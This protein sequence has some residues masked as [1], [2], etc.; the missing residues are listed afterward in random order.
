MSESLDFSEAALEVGT[1]YMSP[2]VHVVKITEV[3]AGLSSQKNTPYVEFTVS[4]KTGQTASQQYYLTTTIK[5]GSTKS[6]FDISKNAIL[7]LIMSS[8]NVD[9]VTAK[10]KLVGITTENIATKLATL[11]VGKTLAIRLNGQ[12]VN[13]TDTNK[14]SWVKAIFGTGKFTATV[15]LQTSLSYDPAKHI[16]GTPATTEVASTATTV[17]ADW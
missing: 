8:L 15:E 10:T 5:E 3:K 16:K 17:K 4:D 2:G 1:T 9:E 13:P 12:W 6:A 14:K 7:Q 11:L